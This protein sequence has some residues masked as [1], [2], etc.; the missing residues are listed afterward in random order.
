MLKIC[1]IRMLKFWKQPP[2]WS[3]PLC[4]ISFDFTTFI[5]GPIRIRGCGNSEAHLHS[6]VTCFWAKCPKV[7]PAAQELSSF[8]SQQE[9]LIKQNVSD[10]M[11]PDWFWNAL[12]GGPSH[13][14]FLTDRLWT[15]EHTL[16]MRSWPESQWGIWSEA[17]PFL[18]GSLSCQMNNLKSI[19]PKQLC[20]HP[21]VS[22]WWT[23]WMK[24]LAGQLF[25][26]FS[27]FTNLQASSSPSM[28]GHHL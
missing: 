25:L 16:L 22:V 6:H 23:K 11:R 8:Y 3:C 19:I 7:V 21:T 27:H 20:E 15:T 5:S 12:W 28:K 17:L 2:T 10:N 24:V 13:F 14:E 9:V 18:S 26:L 1:Q 4:H